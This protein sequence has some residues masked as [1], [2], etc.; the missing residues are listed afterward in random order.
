MGRQLGDA[1]LQLLSA[2]AEPVLQRQQGA[3]LRPEGLVHRRGKGT[4]R[5]GRCQRLAVQ[6]FQPGQGLLI[7][8][9]IE[10][11]GHIVKGAD[12]DDALAQ[13]HLL[14]EG[15]PLP[16]HLQQLLRTVSGSGP[17]LQVVIAGLKGLGIGTGIGD[18]GKH[19]IRLH[20]A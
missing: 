2:G 17:A 11:V 13:S 9:L 7:F 18:I 4:F 12:G 10:G 16:N 8:L 1:G 20:A 5:N 3:Q 14:L 19:P 6:R 15:V